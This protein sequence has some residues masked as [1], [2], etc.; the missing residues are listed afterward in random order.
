M[1]RQGK[2]TRKVCRC[3]HQDDKSDELIAAIKMPFFSDLQNNTPEDQYCC[4][5]NTT[6]T[7]HIRSEHKATDQ[8]PWLFTKQLTRQHPICDELRYA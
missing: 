2:Y 5:R 1:E 8:Q 6:Q 4:D 3:D 7:Q